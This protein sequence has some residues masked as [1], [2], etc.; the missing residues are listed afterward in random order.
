MRN[1]TLASVIVLGVVVVVVG[2]AALL[3]AKT[4]SEAQS[5]NDKAQNIAELGTGVNED[6][7]AVVQLR[8]TNSLATSILRSATPLERQLNGIVGEARSIDRHAGSIND[9]AGTIN[10]T[11][12]QINTTAGNINSSATA[13]DEA[14]G[15][16][17]AS[18]GSINESAGSINATAG[19]INGLAGRVSST[20]GSIN[21]S[22]RS[23]DSVAATILRTA[24]RV[25]TDVSLINQNLDVTLSLA[26]AVKGDTANILNQ[27]TGAH[28]TAACIDRKVLGQASGD[29][30]CRGA[31]TPASAARTRAG[32]Q[33]GEIPNK[34]KKLFKDQEALRRQIEERAKAQQNAPAPTPNSAPTNP[35]PNVGRQLQDRLDGILGNLKGNRAN[36]DGGTNTTGN[37]LLDRL[38]RT[39]KLQKGGE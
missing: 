30:D 38:L 31:A 21:R 18:A 39:L 34:L 3:L 22:A 28:D 23:I 20:A 25:D 4:V 11:A 36:G 33:G 16:I 6:T 10:D 13:I 19:T 17:N 9:S 27:A 1:F 26:T 12:G 15:S 35:L 24:R 29:G 8:R 2:L 5:I 7:D 14:A 32:A 37:A